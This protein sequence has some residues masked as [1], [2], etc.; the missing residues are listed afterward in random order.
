MQ[1]LAGDFDGDGRTD[2]IAL[3]VIEDPAVASNAGDVCG[4]QTVT[5]QTHVRLASQA[6]PKWIDGNMTFTASA[7]WGDPILEDGRGE[8]VHA[9]P[10]RASAT[11]PTMV[12]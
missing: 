4:P 1:F 7:H 9:L 6:N 11:T 10:C 2:A 12:A 5:L 3:G 8:L